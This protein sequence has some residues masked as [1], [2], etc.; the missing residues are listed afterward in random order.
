[1]Q[2][3]ELSIAD[4]LLSEEAESGIQSPSTLSSSTTT[5]TSSSNNSRI[6][7]SS[8][9]SFNSSSSSNTSMTLGDSGLETSQGTSE[10]LSLME[11]PS[12]PN[13][14]RILDRPG[15]SQTT[16]ETQTSP[17]SSQNLIAD[18]IAKK[19]SH[20][21]KRARRRATRVEADPRV[22]NKIIQSARR[23]IRSDSGSSTQ[24]G[25]SQETEADI[26]PVSSPVLDWAS[27]SSPLS[28]LAPATSASSIL[29]LANL[30]KKRIKLLTNQSDTESEGELGS[31]SGQ[32][33]AP[34]SISSPPPLPST[35]LDLC[36]SP[37]SSHSSS[38]NSPG[39]NSSDNSG[40]VNEILAGVAKPSQNLSTCQAEF[41]KITKKEGRNMRK[42]SFEESDSDN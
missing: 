15:I 9:S 28:E 34:S 5:T 17:Q 14:E 42:R 41:K 31:N 2:R 20:L 11:V 36:T 22:V 37:A 1:M 32:N 6:T 10:R 39:N 18:L 16:A 35:S 33:V 19:R 7:T 8:S 3:M 12:S 26:T 30:R 40:T 21:V 4:E 38:L 13:L 25:T 24:S 29:V 27:A 23:V